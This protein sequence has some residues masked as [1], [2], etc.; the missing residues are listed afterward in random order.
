MRHPNVVQLYEIIETSKQI[1][2]VMEYVSYGN[3][4]HAL[5]RTGNFDD[6]VVRSIIQQI[7][8]ALYFYQR[9]S[10]IHRDIKPENI[11][12]DSSRDGEVSIKLAD[13]AAVG[14]KLKI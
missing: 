10:V 8:S 7:V 2:P 3:L 14:L 5:K 6:K 9:R 4:Y 13:F 12:V 11:M 1:Y